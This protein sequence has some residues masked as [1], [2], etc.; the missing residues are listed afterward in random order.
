MHGALWRLLSVARDF[1]WK[2]FGL[3]TEACCLFW[4][5]DFR[6]L[7][8]TDGEFDVKCDCRRLL[9]FMQ[10]RIHQMVDMVAFMRWHSCSGTCPTMP[11]AIEENMHLQPWK[12]ECARAA[13]KGGGRAARKCVQ[14]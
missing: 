3:V 6:S 8:G 1:A 2:S 5:A 10:S 9:E 14:I 13:C 11:N 12:G 7:E 4:I